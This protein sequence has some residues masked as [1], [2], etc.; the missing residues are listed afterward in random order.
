M[1]QTKLGGMAMQ[2]TKAKYVVCVNGWNNY[3]DVSYALLFTDGRVVGKAEQCYRFSGESNSKERTNSY[4]L[5][6]RES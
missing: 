3:R 5:V 6:K 1:L 2:V 4:D